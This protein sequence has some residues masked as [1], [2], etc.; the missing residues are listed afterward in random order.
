[1]AA[2]AMFG[3]RGFSFDETVASLA[4]IPAPHA[5]EER[6]ARPRAFLADMAVAA[7]LTARE[8]E[9]FELLAQGRNGGYIQRQLGVSY[10]TVKT[11]VAHIYTK[12]GV[13]S[14]QELIDLVE[15]RAAQ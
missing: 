3:M 4:A 6:P 13:H 15:R 5:G 8:R 7:E 1:M 12:F 10:N 2:Y 9:V 14:H 11:H